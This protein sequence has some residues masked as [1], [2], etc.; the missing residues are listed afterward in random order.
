M[1]FLK[2]IACFAFSEWTTATEMLR[3]P[4]KFDRSEVFIAKLSI[5]MSVNKKS[6]K[7]K[8]SSEC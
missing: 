6:L 3:E 4:Q 8:I 1:N 2:F 7:T 5:C